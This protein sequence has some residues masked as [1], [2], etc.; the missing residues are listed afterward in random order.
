MEARLA[1][2]PGL[3][4]ASR[5]SNGGRAP[6]VGVMGIGVQKAATSWLYRCLVEHPGLRGSDREG[7]DKEINFF[8][9]YHEYGYDWYERQFAVGAWQN[10]EFSVLY[11]HDRNV[12]ARIRR[13]NPD[14]RLVL[15]LRNPV[16]RALSQYRHEIRH[17]RI[18]HV[19]GGFWQALERNPSYVEQGLYALHLERWLEHFDRSRFHVVRYDDVQSDP[20]GVLERAMGFLGV[21]STFRPSAAGEPRNRSLVEGQGTGRR[22]LRGAARGL[23]LT[24][25]DRLVNRIRGTRMFRPVQRFRYVEVGGRDELPAG[26]E[27]R[28]RLAALF[29]SDLR[30]LGEI[31]G[32]DYGHWR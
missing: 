12:P 3:S 26:S 11:F 27:A 1:E 8:N 10:M 22:L 21:D 29:E 19:P 25:G 23:R 14:A 15:C 16:D 6:V 2:D 5:R 7:G 20:H 28:E 18:T 24:L 30:H 32:D 31:L 13:Y 9:R 4:D 17:G